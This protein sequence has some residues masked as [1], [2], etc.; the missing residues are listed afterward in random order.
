MLKAQQNLLFQETN[1]ILLQ[2]RQFEIAYFTNLYKTFG[3]LG[4]IIAGFAVNSIAQ[5]LAEEAGVAAEWKTAFWL[6]SCFTIA[7]SL[8]VMI[9]TSLILVHGPGLALR[10][11]IGSMKKAVDGMYAEQSPILI[12]TILAIASFAIELVTIFVLEMYLVE[13]WVSSVIL[14]ISSV[15]WY[16]SCI[17]IYNRFKIPAEY[18]TDYSR[19]SDSVD[20]QYKHPIHNRDSYIPPNAMKL[21]LAAE[22]RGSDVTY[23][24]NM[25][26]IDDD[27]RTVKTMLT[28]STHMT[29][30]I[31]TG[32]KTVTSGLLINNTNRSSAYKEGYLIWKPVSD[33]ERRYFVL[34]DSALWFYKDKYHYDQKSDKPVNLRPIKTHYYI[35]SA[36]PISATAAK[37]I[38]EFKLVPLDGDTTDEHD[39]HSLIKTWL[40]RSDTLEEM[41]DWIDVLQRAARLHESIDGRGSFVHD[42]MSQRTFGHGHASVGGHSNMSAH[43]L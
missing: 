41:E 13:A 32:S 11:P 24:T 15:F 31:G 7:F 40:F 10:G 5:V 14:L 30:N 27:T 17:R 39:T 21:R 35:V 4:I 8:H 43:D 42:T 6:A 20:Q 3:L 12:S 36:V 2:I 37:P 25:T 33:W 34:T 23:E 38:F 29:S 9:I 1:Q 16:N 28:Q 18:E 26:S 19:R 22:S